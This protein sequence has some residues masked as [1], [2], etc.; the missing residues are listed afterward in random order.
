MRQFAVPHISQRC[1]WEVQVN[2]LSP[3]TL[4]DH[5]ERALE[6]KDQQARY[7]REGIMAYDCTSHSSNIKTMK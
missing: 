6:L 3:R 2:I 1:M 7:M 4:M 5:V